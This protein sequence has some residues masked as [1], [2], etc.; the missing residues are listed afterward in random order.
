M[1]F[2]HF[3]FNYCQLQSW[4]EDWKRISESSFSITYHTLCYPIFIMMLHNDIFSLIN[5]YAILVYIFLAYS[6]ARKTFFIRCK[7]DITQA[8]P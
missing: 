2:S 5:L 8:H 7:Y 4:L 6:T 3:K 1:F